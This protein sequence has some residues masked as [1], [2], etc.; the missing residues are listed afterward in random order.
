MLIQ[1]AFICEVNMCVSIPEAINYIDVILNLY[2]KASKFATLRNI[3]KQFYP[4]AWP[5]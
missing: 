3:M 1:L 4:W 5:Q 2:I